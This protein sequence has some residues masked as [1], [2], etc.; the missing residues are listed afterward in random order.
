LES[1]S[2]LHPFSTYWF[3]ISGGE[4]LPLKFPFQALTYLLVK[5]W[6]YYCVPITY[7]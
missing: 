4:H 1:S 6:Q 2:R 7:G 3:S 5:S